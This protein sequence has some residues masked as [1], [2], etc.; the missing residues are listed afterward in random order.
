MKNPVRSRRN[1]KGA[2][3]PT[4][5]KSVRVFGRVLK[6]VFALVVVSVLVLASQQIFVRANQPISEI[7]IGGEF[8]P[9]WTGQIETRLAT[10]GGMG[11][12]DVDLDQ[13]KSE[14][15]TL[16]WV[17]KARVS[18]QWPSTLVVDLEE[19]R[20]VARW[21]ETGYVSDQGLKIEGYR[22]DEDLPLLRSKAAEPME[23]LQ[24]Y[25]RLS[26]AMSQ[27]N[28]QLIELHESSTGD[29]ELFL[30]NGILLKLGNKDLLNRIQRF[31]AV[32][33][34]ELFQRADSIEGI[35]VRYAN[36]LAVNWNTGL[37]HGAGVQHMG[38]AYG[39]LAGR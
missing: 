29:L 37:A 36:G 2:T 16:P 11:L 20:L 23:L 25:R 6:S 7:Q 33:K 4:K 10:Y 5:G 8:D 24:Q 22:A 30:E 31:I 18:R 13:L 12:L 26:Q 17:A 15:E 21:N 32:W 27:I 14:V 34:L 28:L 38:D 3:R 9:R 39:E 1:G 35:D 19:H